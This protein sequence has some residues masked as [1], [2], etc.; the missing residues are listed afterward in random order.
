MPSIRLILRLQ[1]KD[2]DGSQSICHIRLTH[3]IDGQTNED[4]NRQSSIKSM[5][6]LQQAYLLNKMGFERG[7]FYH[8]LSRGTKL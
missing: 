1:A 7:T 3:V 2:L 6:K 5:N 4:I 8:K